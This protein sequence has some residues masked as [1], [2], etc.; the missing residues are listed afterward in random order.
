MEPSYGK[1]QSQSNYPKVLAETLNQLRAGSGAERNG[2]LDFWNNL[3]LHIFS[4]SVI[5]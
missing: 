1:A 2:A 4:Q 5:Q 3:V